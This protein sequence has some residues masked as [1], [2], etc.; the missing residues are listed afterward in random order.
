MHPEGVLIWAL[1]PR[2]S[3]K[4]VKARGRPMASGT[5]LIVS[6]KMPGEDRPRIAG[7]ARIL[8]DGSGL[9][10][11]AKTGDSERISLSGVDV[12]SIDSLR[13]LPKAS[14]R[15]RRFIN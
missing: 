4:R 14:M 13:S 1:W 10:L 15:R 7:V 3:A 12:V 8:V 5:N 11:V 2:P 6:L 9:T